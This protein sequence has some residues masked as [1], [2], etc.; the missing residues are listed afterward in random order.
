M[1]RERALQNA[2]K[3]IEKITRDYQLTPEQFRYVAKKV[4]EQV[5][6]QLPR[7]RRKL[8]DYLSPPEIYKILEV[9]H[10]V[11]RFDGV[12]IEFLI[13]TG[14]RI[15]EAKQLMVGH[16]DFGGN[17]VKVVAGKG[18][19]DRYV[20]ISNNLI[21]KIRLLIGGRSK[22]VLF[23]KRN[24]TMYSTRT[25]QYRITRIIRACGFSKD[26]TTHSLR[27]TFACLCL[28]RG[29]PIEQIKILLGHESIKTTEIYAKI[30]LG[31]IKEKYLQ[32][33]G[34]I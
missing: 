15:S 11:D 3:K 21:S 27:H 19:K 4:R 22:G 31:A 29:I 20:P 2:I 32:I 34:G 17:Q 7:S 8:P 25:L 14:L 9:A 5:G 6:L 23:A 13:F 26:L 30:E 24:G 12:L 18:G 33:M 16:L 28:S 10:A 1:K